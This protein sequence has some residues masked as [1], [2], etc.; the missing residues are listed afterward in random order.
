MKVTPEQNQKTLK[1]LQEF[2]E[3]HWD[4]Y[5]SRKEAYQKYLNLY[6]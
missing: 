6:N 4:K 1:A 5:V 2:R 3:K